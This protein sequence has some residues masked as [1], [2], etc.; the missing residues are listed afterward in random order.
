MHMNASAL[1]NSPRRGCI[2]TVKHFLCP[3]SHKMFVL[4]VITDFPMSVSG[5]AWPWSEIT[6]SGN[7][8]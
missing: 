4:L 3:R 2:C 5:K 1:F 7:G 6:K 8:F